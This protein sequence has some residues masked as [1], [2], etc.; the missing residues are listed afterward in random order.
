M[1]YLFDSIIVQ[2]GVKLTKPQREVI[3]NKFKVKEEEK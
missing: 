2:S 1:E 3:K